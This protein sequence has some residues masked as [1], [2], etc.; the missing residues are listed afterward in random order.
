MN[1]EVVIAQISLISGT[2]Y[3]LRKIIHTLVTSLGGRGIASAGKDE[4]DRASSHYKPLYMRKYAMIYG[5]K[6][7]SHTQGWDVFQVR[8]AVHLH[9]YFVSSPS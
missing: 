7:R 3:I 6:S 5:L 8:S 1:T 4:V 9:S 2:P